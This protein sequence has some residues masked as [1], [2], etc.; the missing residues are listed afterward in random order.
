MA[1]RA[2]LIGLLL[3]LF[4]CQKE[5]K[6]RIIGIQP[7]N[8]FEREILDSLQSTLHKMYGF[9]VV[10]LEEKPLPKSA[11]VNIKSPRYRADSLIKILKNT[12][13]DSL[14]YVLGLTE[15]D[16]ST[17]KRDSKGKILLP[18][19]KYRDWGVFGLGFC[20]GKSCVVSTFRLDKKSVD[21]ARFFSRLSK[22]STHEMGHNL[23]LAHCPNK[24]CVMQDAAE[25]IVTIDNVE[26]RLCGECSGKIGLD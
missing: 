7:Y 14:S 10:V 17:T 16:I 22:I 26:L 13:P 23:G 6:E 2:F 11:F 4:S 12:K 3:L 24:E 9:T 5:P 21:R 8:H 18:E 20:P 1:I 19:Q 25:T 15:R